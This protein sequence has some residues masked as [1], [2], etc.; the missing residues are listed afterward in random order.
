MPLFD[1]DLT[2]VE[3]MTPFPRDM[4]SIDRTILA[5]NPSAQPPR[6]AICQIPIDAA[7]SA[8]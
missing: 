6:A 7:L 5:S 3:L 8:R 4:G 2:I 1:N